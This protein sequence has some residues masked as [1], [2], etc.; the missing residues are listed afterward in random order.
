MAATLWGLYWRSFLAINF[1]GSCFIFIWVK[2]ASSGYISVVL[3]PT[4][5]FG[6]LGIITIVS[7]YYK[8]GLAYYILGHRLGLTSETWMKYHQFL[9]ALFLI[10][11]AGLYLIYLI[12]AAHI[13]VTT[14][15]FGS[16]FLLIFSYILVGYFVVKW[17]KIQNVVQVDGLE[18]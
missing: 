4:L 9:G 8:R 15:V 16:A 14:R 11:A 12:G 18:S 7:A 13:W 3:K 6:I 5:M 2:F 17:Q 10:F 1:I